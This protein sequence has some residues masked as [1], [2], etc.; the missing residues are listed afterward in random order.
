MQ[1][2]WTKKRRH[3]SHYSIGRG[4]GAFGLYKKSPWPDTQRFYV[5]RRDS[6]TEMIRGLEF[7][8]SS[9]LLYSKRALHPDTLD[10]FDPAHA[11]QLNH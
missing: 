9:R 8:V 11:A 4:L 7:G 10:S 2:I 5:T 1:L 6:W 3:Y